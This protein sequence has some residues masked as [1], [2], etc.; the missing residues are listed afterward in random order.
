MSRIESTFKNLKRPALVT[1]ITAGNPDYAKSLS[2]LKILPGAGA[3]IIELGMPFTDPMADGP[4]IEQAGIRALASGAN[5][6]KT[7]EMVREFR[8]DNQST[9]IVLMGYA[10]P[11][12]QYGNEKFVQ[13]AAEAGVDGLIVVDLPPE[14]D[15]ELRTAAKKAGIDIIR[16]LTPTTDDKRLPRVLEGASGFLYYVS[17]TGITG[18]GSANVE[19]IR[20]HI[21]QIKAATKLPIV[22]GFGIKTPE[23]AAK[24]AAIGDAVVVGS[25][26]V[27]NIADNRDNPQ[28]T[29]IVEKQV[30]SL[31]SGLL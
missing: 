11:I 3:D 22:I 8:K 10:N 31:A 14:E 7:L 18:A 13:H 15:S 4:V 28:L 9:P 1:F 30:K 29:Q 5:M 25:A 12:L 16:L 2:I 23:D 27:Q 6:N 20:P 21:A 24:M 26:I 17:V 19:T